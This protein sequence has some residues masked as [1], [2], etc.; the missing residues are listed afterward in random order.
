MPAYIDSYDR[1]HQGEA[2]S[3]ALTCPHCSVLSHIT[4]LAVPRHAELLATRPRQVGIVYRCDACNSPVFLRFSIR[5][6]GADRIELS[7]H[8]TELE[9][10]R[11]KFSFTYLPEA[12]ETVFREA[13][14]CYSHGAFNAFASMCRRT[15]QSAFADLGEAGKLRIFDELNDLRAMAQIDA[16]SFTLIKRVIFSTDADASGGG[17]PLLDDDQAGLLVEVIKDL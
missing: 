10:P 15:M 14:L 3:L 6:F 7:P 17:V 1:L 13:L 8:F 12:L 16:A 9:R 11:E 2:S 4:P 5:S